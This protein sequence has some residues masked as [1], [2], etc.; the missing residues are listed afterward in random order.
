[1]TNS[2]TGYGYHADFINGWDVET[3]QSAVSTCTNPSGRV[4]DCPVFA[5]SL[6]TESEQGECKIQS[7][8][9]ALDADDCAGPSDGLCGNVPVQYGPEYAAPLKGG[10]KT[11]EETIKPSLS[12]VAPVPTLSYASARSKG[13]TDAYG[14]GISVFAVKTS[15]T[16]AASE[17]KPT[18]ASSAA[19]DAYAYEAAAPA[20]TPAAKAED[21][22]AEDDGI[23]STTI[24]TRDG[25]VY[26]VA[27]KEVIQY[28]TVEAKRRRHAHQHRRDRS[29]GVM[30][31][32]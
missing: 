22:T 2:K 3:L 21:A 1:L 19:A 11:D 5:G 17:A 12:S 16:P 7:M 27:I 9:K 29:H 13:A 30:G 23:V 20:V 25:V 15:A 28:V 10:D 6:Q 4:E 26:E 24:Y 14:G 32:K 8:P 31:R 18:S